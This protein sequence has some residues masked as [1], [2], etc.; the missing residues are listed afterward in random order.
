MTTQIQQKKFYFE[1][2]K[3]YYLNIILYNQVDQ[4]K[5]E[6]ENMKIQ[7][8]ELNKKKRRKNSEIK[9]LHVCQHCLKTYGTYGAKYKHIKIKHQE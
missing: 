6:I 2:L 1:A 9:K 3:F 4:V 7:F 8:E 5:M